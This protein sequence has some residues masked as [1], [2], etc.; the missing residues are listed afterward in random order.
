ME[1][2][3]RQI[4]FLVYDWKKPFVVFW[5]IVI[6]FNMLGYYI[7]YRTGDNGGFGMVHGLTV[8]LADGTSKYIRYVN[9]AAA[10]IIP[11][12]IFL[13]VYNLIMYGE[14]F[15]TAVGF[16]ST[17]KDFYRAV[18][19]HNIIICTSM[20]IIEA[21]L[22][23]LDTVILRLLGINPLAKVSYFDTQ[24]DNI[25]YIFFMVFLQALLFCAIMNL[26]GALTYKFTVKLWFVVGAALLA[27]MYFSPTASAVAK[28]LKAT[29]YYGDFMYFT[30]KF[31]IIS[32]IMYLL[33][34]IFVRRMN[35]RPGK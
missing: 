31:L 25:F 2:L 30:I 29:F 6:L 10:N 3:K 8:E 12:M 4:K 22:L 33:G 26:L 1:G 27:V 19:T 20:A 28:L 13:F 15:S 14:G 11:A 16:S 17:R 35:V 32:S 24:A 34:W 9:V 21:V 5:I 7:N 18:I 23:K